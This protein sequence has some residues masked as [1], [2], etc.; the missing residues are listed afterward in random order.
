MKKVSKEAGVRSA[1]TEVI[2]ARTLPAEPS[3]QHWGIQKEISTSCLVTPTEETLKMTSHTCWGACNVTPGKE[4][5]ENDKL[6]RWEEWSSK[7][8]VTTRQGL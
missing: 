3:L 5:R 2:R 1:A 4:Y 6:S 8:K 7:E